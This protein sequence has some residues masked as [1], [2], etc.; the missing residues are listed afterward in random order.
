MAEFLEAYLARQPDFALVGCAA[1]GEA[2]WKL[3]LATRPDLVLVDIELPG[4]DGLEL[5]KRLLAQLPGIRLL[6][7]SGLMDPYTIWRVCQS[8][9]HGYIV[10]TQSGESLVQAVRQVAEGGGFFSPVFQ[11]IKD[12]WLAQP[13]AFQKILSN[14]EQE[15]LR[16]VVAGWDDA[17]VAAELGITATTVAAHRK[18][19]RQKTG[20]HSDRDLVAY[21]RRWGI[22]TAMGSVGNGQ[23]PL[24]QKVTQG[25]K[26]SS[27]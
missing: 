8:G 6:A 27:V 26:G 11:K 12:E 15:V 19:I 22:N 24:R 13:E 16:F 7:M 1:N 17:R 20:L 23:L 25:E 10:K 5:A 2:G 9:V 14:R 4:L 21:A 18:H 3:C